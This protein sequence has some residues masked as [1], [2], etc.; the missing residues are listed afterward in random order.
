M[1]TSPT[2]IPGTHV[3][4]DAANFAVIAGPDGIGRVDI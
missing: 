2:L 1:A 4:S 3:F